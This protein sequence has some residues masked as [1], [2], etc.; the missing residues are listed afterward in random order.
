MNMY[1]D[2]GVDF[3]KIDDLSRPYHTGE[4]TMIRKAIDQ[5]GRPIVLSMSP[6]ETPLSQYEHCHNNANMWRTVDDFWDNW[7][8]L[9]YQFTVCAKWAPY[10]DEGTWPDA[11]MLPMG[12]LSIRGERGSE[13]FTNFTKDEQITMM[14]LWTIFKSPLMF[15]GHLPENDDFT[16]SLLTNKDVLYMHANSMNNRQVLREDNKILWSADDKGGKDKF[17]ALF[18]VGG[19]EFIHEKKALY[20]SGTIS[21]LTT[22]YGVD[23]E[24]GR[25]HV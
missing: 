18:N 12:K 2:W 23:M 21:Y 6:G 1:A 3:I 10:I 17:A 15:G 20:R 24:I 25:A 8:Q 19:D 14:S 7:T 5:T 22:G 11:D 4:I 13:R 16:N 9:Q